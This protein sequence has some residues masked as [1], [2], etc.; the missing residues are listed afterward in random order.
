VKVR[1][2]AVRK[3]KGVSQT[4]LARAIGKTPGAMWKYEHNLVPI[5]VDD[6]YIIAKALGVT[7]DEL[8]DEDPDPPACPGGARAEAP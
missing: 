4:A 1:I 6:L 8:V 3:A 2:R 7:I 5:L